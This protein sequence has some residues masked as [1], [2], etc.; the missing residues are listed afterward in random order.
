MNVDMA[1]YHN[2]TANSTGHVSGK[3][4]NQHNNKSL[5]DCS[6]TDPK[7]MPL[8]RNAQQSWNYAQNQTLFFWDMINAFVKLTSI[9]TENDLTDFK[10]ITAA[11]VCVCEVDPY[12]G[13]P[14]HFLECQGDVFMQGC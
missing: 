11:W 1:I 10:N 4:C 2:F 3:Y 7:F 14:Y 5:H 13:I 12:F 9:P 6:A 8:S